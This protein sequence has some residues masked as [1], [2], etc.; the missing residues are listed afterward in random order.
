MKKSLLITLYILLSTCLTYA[1]V[2]YEPIDSK[3]YPFLERLANRGI[4]EFNIVQKPISRTEIAQLL[5]KLNDNVNLTSIERKELT[6][7][8]AEFG[9]ELYT[10][11]VYKKSYTAGSDKYNRFRPYSYESK[12]FYLAA[13]PIAG[14]AI[15]NVNEK[16][17][18]E[19]WWGLKFYGYIG[20]N[21]GYSFRFTDNTVDGISSNDRSLTGPATG[22]V[23]SR[24]FPDKYE[25]SEIEA[26]ISYNWNWGEISLQKSYFNWGFGK[27]G[28]IVLSDRAP[29][30]PNVSVTLYPTDWIRFTYFNGWLNSSIIDS[31]SAYPTTRGPRQRVEYHKKY[32]ASHTLTFYPIA[33]LGIS[34]GESI[35]YSDSFELA[36]AIPLMFFRSAD[37]Y[38]SESNNDAGSNSQFFFNVS[39]RGHIPNTHLYATLYID[40]V[41]ASK[42]FN[43]DESKSQIALNLGVSVNDIPVDNI[44]FSFEYSRMNPFIYKHYIPTQT[45]QNAGYNLGHWVGDNAQIIYGSLGY[46]ILRGLEAE[47]SGT[48]ITQGE[49]GT[50]EQQYSVPQPDFLFGLQTKT[51][52]LGFSVYYEPIHELIIRGNL[53]SEKIVQE[54]DTGN[55]IEVSNTNFIFSVHYGL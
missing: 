10:G 39:S 44:D 46:R 6:F 14:A 50:V 41:I 17:V 1:Q 15:S 51:T 19:K 52:M 3:V 40:E 47:L 49:E 7:Y 25:F 18:F 21:F 27:T 4:I 42:I 48:F 45:Y 36:Y 31:S 37:H 24:R 34:L 20:E 26:S 29:S 2:V 33:G 35:I 11:M 22:P 8:Q 53:T 38:L 32:I 13:S 23:I 5:K 55:D 12:D 28:Q 54:V 30:F 9:R 16:D 43:S